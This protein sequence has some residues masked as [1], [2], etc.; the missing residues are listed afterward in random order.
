MGRESNS[1]GRGGRGRGARTGRGRGRTSSDHK[2]KEPTKYKEAELKFQPYGTVAG[3][4]GAT[5][6]TV[7]DAIVQNIQ[8]NYDYG[9]DL[10]TSLRD[11]APYDLK[12]HKP[13]LGRSTEIDP[14]DKAMEQRGLEILYQEELSLY[15]R[16]DK[17]MTQNKV[18]AYAMIFGVYCTKVMQNRVEQHHD[19]ESTIQDDPIKL[20]EVIQVLMHD[21]VRGK[22]PFAS[23]TECFMSL[24][25]MKQAPEEPI[26]EYAK[27]FKQGR[28][29]LRQH[30]GEDV[31]DHF[32]QTTKD[33]RD[34]TTLEDKE[35]IRKGAFD[36][37]NA[38][39]FMITSDQGKYGELINGISTQYAMGVNQFPRNVGKA[40]DVLTQFKYNTS[41]YGQKKSWKDQKDKKDEVKIKQE[42]SF[43]QTM[44]D[45]TCFCCGKKGHIST[46]CHELKTRKKSDWVG[47]KS[48]GTVHQQEKVTSTEDKDEDKDTSSEKE[49]SRTRRPA[50]NNLQVSLHEKQA[51][52]PN[53]DPR[54]TKM[55]ESIILDNG[56]TL[57]I[58]GNPKLV[59]N[60]R[61]SDT[62]LELATNAGTLETDQVAEVPGFGTV[63]YDSRAIANIFGLNDLKDKYRVTYD[64]K[65][66]DTFKVHME[67]KVIEFKCNKEGLYEYEVSDEYKETLCESNKGEQSV[68]HLIETI[69]ENRVGYTDRQFARA[70]T[71][72]E[73]Y[74]NIGSP[75]VA[76]FKALLKMNAIKN[77]PVV[78]D[79]V[80]NAEK[81]F[82]PALSTLKGKS[83]RRKP[84]P[85]LKDEI[86]IPEELKNLPRDLELCMDVM[87]INQQPM[88]TTIDKSIRFRGIVPLNS[89]SHDEYYQALDQVLR[90]YNKAGYKIDK[91][92]C[93][94]EFKS[95]MD[96]VADDLNVT[97]NYTNAQDHV[98]EAERNNR[99][100]KE[101]MRAALHR[102]PYKKIPKT[103]IT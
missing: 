97:M 27:R 6:Q 71:A 44:K 96:K 74:H 83:T 101:K 60:I 15:L 58:F 16:R 87:Y 98:P 26:G 13:T 84:K 77:C 7:K 48:K 62:T 4:I 20:L 29:V 69:S 24:F 41:K 82:G 3:K 40:L 59:E 95:M 79:D 85:V 63:W 8:R 57:S 23:M 65:H 2:D 68:S 72:R 78:L 61:K 90:F 10:A 76:N 45:A 12:Q 67:E 11:M 91:I 102:L 92:Y 73:L 30:I 88:L 75:T 9:Q 103:M 43:A 34:A 19:F 94:G 89:T 81:I 31:L 52:G 22:Y 17:A 25:K 5:Y 51:K 33:Y 32:V 36:R 53:Q 37:W 28:D 21:S 46:H 100:I 50:W 54:L 35:E 38:Y 18:K 80:I 55:R 70:K 86:E 47:D 66:G 56:S 1:E 14:T 99:T 93:D 49:A 64:S 39:I 42:S